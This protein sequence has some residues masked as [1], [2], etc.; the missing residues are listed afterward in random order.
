[1]GICCGKRWEKDA[2]RESRFV[3]NGREPDEAALRSAR[4]QCVADAAMAA[5]QIAQADWASCERSPSRMP[6]SMRR[7]GETMVRYSHYS[8]VWYPIRRCA[9]PYSCGSRPG[10]MTFPGVSDNMRSS[11]VALGGGRTSILTIRMTR[12]STVDGER[13][14]NR[15]Y[16]PVRTNADSSGG[17][18]RRWSREHDNG[19]AETAA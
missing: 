16:P 19:S 10:F 18:L 1:M 17:P 5:V 12:P 9:K 2:P 14:F 7:R 3:E 8:R 4:L 13:T 15:L 11:A 6:A